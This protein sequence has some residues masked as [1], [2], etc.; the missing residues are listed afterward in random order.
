MGFL[1][2]RLEDTLSNNPFSFLCGNKDQ[3][4][5]KNKTKQTQQAN[6]TKQPI[7]SKIRQ[8]FFFLCEFSDSEV[9]TLSFTLKSLNGKSRASVTHPCG[10]S[11]RTGLGPECLSPHRKPWGAGNY[12]F[13]IS[14]GL[15][16]YTRRSLSCAH[17]SHLKESPM[18]AQFIPGFSHVHTAHIQRYLLC[19]HSSHLKVSLSC[20][21]SSH[22]KVSLKCTQQ[23]SY[24]L[25]L[26]MDS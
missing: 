1:P 6:K 25:P 5:N 12:A 8:G 3:D 23:F 2:W 14:Q 17:S 4:Q 9:A 18:C 11:T 7:L 13:F 16:I 21:H 20:A 26:N 15:P 19:V 24:Y 10:K 22:L